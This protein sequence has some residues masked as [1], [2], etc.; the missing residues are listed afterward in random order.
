MDDQLSIQC[1]F[2]DEVYF[3]SISLRNS[4]IFT[5]GMP[6]R[7]G[8]YLTIQNNDYHPSM[9]L[10]EMISVLPP[11]RVKPDDATM[12]NREEFADPFYCNYD[13]L[14]NLGKDWWTFHEM[15]LRDKPKNHFLIQNK[16]HQYHPRPI[17]LSNNPVV[18]YPRKPQKS[19]KGSE[20]RI[21]CR[22][23]MSKCLRL[24]CRCFKDLEYCMQ[25]CKCTSCYNN[26]E[27][28]EARAFVISKTKEITPNAFSS[29][30][31][32]IEECEE[33]KINSEGCNC[34]KGCNRNYCECF[35][36]NVNCSSLCNCLEC[37][38]HQHPLKTQII[39]SI[40]KSVRTKNKIV[41]GEN[42][43][44]EVNEF[45]DLLA[46][47]RSDKRT[48]FPTMAESLLPNNDPIEPLEKPPSNSEPQIISY[49]N[50][51]RIKLD[52]L[53]ISKI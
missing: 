10:T 51:K 20:K 3:R 19:S 29:K 23:N 26:L 13:D 4:A 32:A 21:G 8:A 15:P 1:D 9:E 36:N 48:S 49:Q 30:I 44:T 45:P 42:S 24:H 39:T 34:K 22:C 38:N 27:H 5:A 16:E 35:K 14:H 18:K 7:G 33:E 46:D 43:K 2:N 53:P 52:T 6:N 41:F 25:N 50:Y 40:S 11:K 47:Y 28:E 17:L 12:G 37:K 31:V